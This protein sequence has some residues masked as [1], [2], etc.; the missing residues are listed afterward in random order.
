V[1]LRDGLRDE[2]RQIDAEQALEKPVCPLLRPGSR[3]D[4]LPQP[5]PDRVGELKHSS[6]APRLLD[7]EIATTS[8]PHPRM[9]AASP[10]P[11][12]DARMVAYRGLKVSDLENLRQ[13]GPD[14]FLSR[15][16]N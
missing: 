2:L 3:A 5:H 16:E 4:H 9:A 13:A 8:A 12:I 6:E 14:K 15:A 1:R 11:T 10:P 7:H